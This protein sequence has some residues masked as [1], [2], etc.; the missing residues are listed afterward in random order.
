MDGRKNGD[1]N[2][3]I[4]RGFMAPDAKSVGKKG[5]ERSV[6]RA[7]AATGFPIR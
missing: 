5:G 7:N 3:V 2:G 6:G 1:R 4:V